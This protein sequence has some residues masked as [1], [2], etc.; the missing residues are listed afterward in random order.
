MADQKVLAQEINTVEQ[1]LA[2]F[3]QLKA[4]LAQVRE[5]LTHSHR[6]ATLGT[7]ASIIA[8]EYNNILTPVISYAQLAL[9]KPD[10][11]P[12]MRK[13]VERALAGAERA[14][15]ISSSLL[16][17]AR[18][19]DQAHAAP[20]PATVDAAIACLARDPRKDGIELVV[21]V[22]DVQ[23][24]IAPLNLEQVLV[25]LLLNAR[26][27]MKPRGGS[28]TIRGRVEADLVKIDVS[29]TGPG[30]PPQIHGRLFE[31][32]VTMRNA[33][34]GGEPK[35]TGLGLSI[36]RDLISAVGGS[37]EVESQ[38]GQGAT[39]HITLPKADDLFEST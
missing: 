5:G 29:D 6:L 39:F 8:H 20:L 35:G 2:Q 3:N 33:S 9:A 23:V 1:L 25:N 11:A 24:S 16:G 22:P 21:D 32:F 7:I 28:I 30:I 26:Q 31:P 12:L 19:A 18:E 37:I 10:D 15:H 17:F 36:C 27:A 34:G 4:Q 38:P 14:A 13:A